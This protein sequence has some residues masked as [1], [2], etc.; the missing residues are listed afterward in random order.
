MEC[1]QVIQLQAYYEKHKLLNNN[2]YVK[3]LCMKNFNIELRVI[4]RKIDVKKAYGLL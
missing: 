2:Y 4:K 3:I 1:N